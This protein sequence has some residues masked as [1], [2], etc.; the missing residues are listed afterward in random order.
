MIRNAIAHGIE[1]PAERLQ[2]GKPQEGTVQISF[3]LDD[4]DEYELTVED[5]G[6]GLNYDQILDRAMQLDLLSPQ[7]ALSLDGINVY[8]LIFEPGFSTADAIS[9]HAGRGVGLDA[10]NVR[11]REAGG[12]IAV[13]T[14]A[15]QYTRFRVLLPRLDSGSAASVA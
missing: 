14:A 5:D 13:A 12:R 3:A 6:A 8:R 1:P 7:Q 2:V 9:E 15:G 11:V 10:V 4:S